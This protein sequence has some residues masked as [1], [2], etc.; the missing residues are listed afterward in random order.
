MISPTGKGFGNRVLRGTF[1]H[2]R[3]EN[4]R[5]IEKSLC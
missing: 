3:I 4:N 1:G 2:E 5:R